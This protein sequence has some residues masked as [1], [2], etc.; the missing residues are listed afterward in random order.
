MKKGLLDRVRDGLTNRGK[1]EPEKSASDESTPAKPKPVQT[2]AQSGLRCPN[3]VCRSRDLRVE[4][5]RSGSGAKV[6][7]RV[8]NRC[9]L[10]FKTEETVAE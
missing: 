4:Y 3:Q 7:I 5:S 8:C 1:D 6:R 9:G 10:R 2:S